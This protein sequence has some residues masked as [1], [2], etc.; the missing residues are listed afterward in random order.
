MTEPNKSTQ[1]KEK[2]API[3]RGY[4]QDG[5]TP[6]ELTLWV[7]DVGD[8]EKAP[9]MTG[10]VKV[11]NETT[12]VSAWF[13]PAGVRAATD[14]EPE[15]EYG[16]FLSIVANIKDGEGW[17]SENLGSVQAMLRTTVK[18]EKIDV[19]GSHG[20]KLIGTLKGQTVLNQGEGTT[21]TGNMN[22]RF[23]DRE[24]LM[25]YAEQL[26]FKPEMLKGFEAFIDKDRKQAAKP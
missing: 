13:R 21:V 1:P 12:R 2:Q 6:A 19:D 11:G 7:N 23:A 8:N 3:I 24:A 16:A 5:K 25:V 26:G 22:S 9:D 10:V 20:L 15:K 17:K 4:T 14:T 18:G